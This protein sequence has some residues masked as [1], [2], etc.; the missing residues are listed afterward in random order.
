MN[1]VMK[2]L[3][4]AMVFVLLLGCL[5]GCKTD[6]GIPTAPAQEELPAGR[7]MGRYVEEDIPIPDATYPLDLV[8][9]SDGRLRFAAWGEN[10]DLNLYTR[11]AEGSWESTFLPAEI[12]DSGSVSALALSPE[13]SI[14][15]YTAKYREDWTIGAHHLWLV[16]PAGQARE[17]PNHYP[18][19]DSVDFNLITACDFT[20]DGRLMVAIQ[21][22]ELRELDPETGDFGENRNDLGI[23]GGV[24][25][26]AGED[27][28][29]LGADRGLVYG[30][31]AVTTLSDPA[32]EQMIRT[33]AAY[34]GT[35][36]KKITLWE[37]EEGYLFFTT[38]E[39]LYSFVPGG[40]VTEELIDGDRTSLG[41]P[42]FSPFSLVGDEDGSFYILGIS[43]KPVLL[44][45]VYDENIPTEPETHLR[46]YSLRED[47]S[48]RQIAS[49][50]QK[51]N[52]D[53][54]VDLE[55]GMTGADGITEGDAIKA[56]NTRILSGDG[57]DIVSLDGLPLQSFLEKGILKDLGDVL[58]ASAPLLTQVTS[59][60]AVDGQV[61]AMPTAFAIPVI[62]GPE[63]IFSQVSGMDSLVN[64]AQQARERNP[65][66]KS[67]LFAIDPVAMADA[68]YDGCSAAWRKADGT[69]EESKLTEY[70]AG[71]KALF[72]LDADYREA[73]GAGTGYQVGENTGLGGAKE[74]L[75][76][77]ICSAGT[78]EG[79]EGW[80]WALAGDQDLSE[81]EALPLNAQ[82]SHV[83]LPRQVMGILNTGREPEAAEA[84]LTFMLSDQ[85]QGG[86]QLS[87]FPVNQTIFDRQIKE[88]REVGG[89]FSATDEND[90]VLVFYNLYLDARRRQMLK[91]WVDALTTPALTDG[92]IRGIVMEQMDSCC[93]GR[94]T[95]QEAAKNALRS[96]NLY[97]S[98]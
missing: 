20:S 48:L 87:G 36:E 30:N 70:Y 38:E 64:A 1:T 43:G 76:G 66:A 98:E 28:Y 46:L 8:M 58:G 90:N 51:A 33:V 73:Y 54:A 31:G 94:I 59:C 9:L 83:F 44:H 12:L 79:M 16:D 19:M 21:Y 77:S 7:A 55:I 29:L 15:C 47:E 68:F 89:G 10:D 50:F 72:A 42:G 18:D 91:T 25:C 41:D 2:I 63:D 80:T 69:L 52:P 82:A 5:A 81:Y 23:Y 75:K 93:N 53:I 32:G 11:T 84:F 45:F 40:S 95:P 71:M 61:C 27:T 24:L 34:D 65:Q 57:P 92:T 3:S 96:L 60:F 88:D 22:Q 78:L 56:L 6:T 67:V 37:N 17:I 35:S 4:L 49:L 85:I 39:G 97:L 86:S 26:C 62:Y 14:F 74:I 13:G